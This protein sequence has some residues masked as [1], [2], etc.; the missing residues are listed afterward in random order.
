MEWHGS[1]LKGN[2]LEYKADL[3]VSGNQ[4][5]SGGGQRL[6]EVLPQELEYPEEHLARGRNVSVI[7]GLPTH[8]GTGRNQAWSAVVGPKLYLRSDYAPG[9]ALDGRAE[10]PKAAA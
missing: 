5:F 7:Q 2:P 3:Y 1:R 9:R 6:S 8:I 4:T 10:K